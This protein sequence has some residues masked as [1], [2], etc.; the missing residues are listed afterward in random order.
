MRQTRK[1]YVGVDLGQAHDYTAITV[2]ERVL[3][4]R[5]IEPATAYERA[6]V[7]AGNPPKT[8]KVPMYRV[9][10]LEHMERGTRYP[11]QVERIKERLEELRG[12]VFHSGDRTY[13]DGQ[14]TLIVDATGVG[15]PV[16]DMLRKQGLKPIAVTITGADSETKADGMHRVPKRN[17]V[18]ALQVLLQNGR[19]KIQ[20]SLHLA[21]TLMK[22]M[23]AFKVKITT[24]G[25]DTYGNDWRENP[26]DDLVLATALAAW[27][28]E[29]HP[30]PDREALRKAYGVS[31]TW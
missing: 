14:C 28:P 23:L 8:E 21:D 7:A 1:F 4:L 17:L 13:F 25:H 27:Y 29:R 11:E 2:I 10:H 5:P 15:R 12:A 22:E 30:K 9:G 6:T 26:H 20:P 16:V 19:L 31:Q 3:T 24:S 18:S